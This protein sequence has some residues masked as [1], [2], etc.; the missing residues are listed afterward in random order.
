MVRT[1]KQQFNSKY[2]QPLGKPNSLKDISRLTGYDIKGLRIIFN[3]GKGAYKS[4]PQSVRPNVTSPE[5]WAYA[6]VYASVNPKS[7]AYKIDKIHLMKK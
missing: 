5:Q 7:K 6:R 1:Y 2:K 3:K 4:N